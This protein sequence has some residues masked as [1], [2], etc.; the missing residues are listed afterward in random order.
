LFKNLFD[1]SNENSL[2]PLYAVHPL[3]NANI[4]IYLKSDD[5]FGDLDSD[6]RPILDAKLG[7]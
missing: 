4:P 5:E 2:L 7:N 3:T 1:A 6:G